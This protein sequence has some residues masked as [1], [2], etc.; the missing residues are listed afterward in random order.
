MI[1]DDPITC[2]VGIP[3]ARYLVPKALLFSECP[4]LF[5]TAL[6]SQF[7]ENEANTL[8]LIEETPA[9]FELFI[10]WLYHG[11]IPPVEQGGSDSSGESA[12]P[13]E[14]KY[15]YLYYLAERWSIKVLKNRVMDCIRAYHADS[16]RVFPRSS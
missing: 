14:A 7:H 8:V 9:T 5:D 11:A 13:R 4:M 15:Y 6:E 16:N 2:K 10:H 1:V 3:E 12:D